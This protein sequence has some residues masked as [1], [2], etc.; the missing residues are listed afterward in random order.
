[1]FQRNDAQ[2]IAIK[3]KRAILTTMQTVRT[4]TLT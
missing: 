3:T 1:M 4:I 2:C